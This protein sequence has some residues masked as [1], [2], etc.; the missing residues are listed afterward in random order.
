M[1]SIGSTISSD[2]SDSERGGCHR[3]GREPPGLWEE[4]QE[5]DP[6]LVSAAPFSLTSGIQATDFAPTCTHR[7][8]HTHIY[9]KFC[10]LRVAIV[11]SRFRWHL[12]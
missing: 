11:I 9:E 4:G 2:R 3:A 6:L 8:R 1:D 12:K 10:L 7:L 5:V